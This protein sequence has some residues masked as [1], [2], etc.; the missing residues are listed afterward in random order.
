MCIGLPPVS[1][2]D[3]VLLY[4]FRTAWKLPYITISDDRD[5]FG[6]RNIGRFENLKPLSLREYFIAKSLFLTKLCGQILQFV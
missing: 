4:A 3:Y 5:K 1:R 2:H 6:S